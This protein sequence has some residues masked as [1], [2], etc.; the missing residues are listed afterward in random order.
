MELTLVL[1]AAG[2]GSRYG[3]LKQLDAFGPS[4]ETLMDYGVYDAAQ[5]GFTRVVFVIRKD[6]EDAFRAQIVPKASKLLKIEIAFQSLEDLPA[7]CSVPEGRTKPWG[8]SH[9]LLAAEPLLT[10]PF[11]VCNA[12]DFYGRAAARSM[13]VFLRTAQP[14]QAALVGYSLGATL[15]EHGTVSRGMC[16]VKDGQLITVTE[17]TKL[18]AG[19]SGVVDELTGA[20]FALDAPA[21]MNYWGFLP[22]ALPHIRAAFKDFLSNMKDP[23][24]S[25]FYLPSA[26]ERG[27]QEHWLK[28]SLLPGGERWFGVT[29]P[30]DKA[31]V[32]AGLAELIQAGIYP[33]NLF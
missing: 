33:N 27:L 4:G 28:V 6:F 24:K 23:L 9:A 16:Q 32:K 15:S 19:T 3:G 8:T 7:G 29:Y 25:E 10:G 14:G 21:S 31:S 22:D 13:A 20:R 5:A 2:M 1:L 11:C 12:D 18:R 26:V 30:E 17:Q